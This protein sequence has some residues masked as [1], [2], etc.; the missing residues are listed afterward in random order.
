MRVDNQPVKQHLRGHSLQVAVFKRSDDFLNPVQLLIKG[1]SVVVGVVVNSETHGLE[2]LDYLS[3]VCLWEHYSIL[4]NE[5]Q[6]VFIKSLLRK[7]IFY[8]KFRDLKF[9]WNLIFL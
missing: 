9:N 4:M 5:M 1:E 8:I 2:H 3:F 6:G 7:Y